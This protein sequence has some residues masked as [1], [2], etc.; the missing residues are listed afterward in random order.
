MCIITLTGA[1]QL[2]DLVETVAHVCHF[3]RPDACTAGKDSTAG[4]DV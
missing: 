3:V 1:E 4:A 2:C